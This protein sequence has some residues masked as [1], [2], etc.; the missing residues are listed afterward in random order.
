MLL[1]KRK[2]IQSLL[3]WKNLYWWNS[4]NRD[5]KMMFETR[6]RTWVNYDITN[7]LI[8]YSLDLAQTRKH[9]IT[10]C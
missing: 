9:E 7:W 5:T 8:Q 3:L 2:Y 4:Q 10:R 6:V 1:G